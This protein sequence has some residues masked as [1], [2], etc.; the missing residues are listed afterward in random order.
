M[1]RP[2]IM[3]HYGG[4]RSKLL[5]AWQ[6]WEG[7][8]IEIATESWGPRAFEL[9]SWAWRWVCW[10]QGHQPYDSTPGSKDHYCIVCRKHLG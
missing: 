2:K 6:E 4:W 8:Y 3:G 10:I 1:T 9:P 7:S 5:R